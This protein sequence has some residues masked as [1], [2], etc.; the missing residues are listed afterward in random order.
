M[1]R[2]G[3]AVAL[4][5]AAATTSIAL[6]V[7]AGAATTSAGPRATLI[8]ESA[9]TDVAFDAAPDPL[10]RTMYFTT[11]GPSGA[12][13]RRVATSGGAT[14]TVLRGGPLRTPR[15]LAVSHDDTRLFVAD[16]A[17]GRIHVVS[18]RSGRARTLRGSRGTAPRGIEVQSRFVVFTGRHAGR[19]AVLRLPTAGAARPTVIASG[20]PLRRPD[21]VAI[22]RTGALYVTDR[23]S[24][25]P[26][27]GRVLRIG[28]HVRRIAAAIRLGTPAGIALTSDDA[29]VLV[30]SLHPTAGTAQVLLVDTTTLATSTFDE[31]IG[32]NRSAG[33]LHRAAAV[34]M[35]GWADVQRPGRVYRIDP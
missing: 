18:L 20:G 27:D 5:A 31:T 35:L 28:R 14:S 13:I 15:N 1:I 30:S 3:S 34:P 17:A 26:R 22:S 23:G 21:A 4:A 10:G 33:G 32:A 7:T 12:A 24:G 29:T 16:P 2:S 19:P 8:A 9:S 6:V 11:G 25:A